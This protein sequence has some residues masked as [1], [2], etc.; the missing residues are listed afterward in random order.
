MTLDYTVEK[1]E[2]GTYKIIPSD[3]EF[4]EFYEKKVTETIE[5]VFPVIASNT[6]QFIVEKNGI[7][8]EVPR[9]LMDEYVEK[10]NHLKV[11]LGDAEYELIC[12][13]AEVVSKHK[14]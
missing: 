9:R 10:I 5:A 12:V 2:D 6:T 4:S 13:D 1:N 11:T 3:K 14:K 8:I 7:K